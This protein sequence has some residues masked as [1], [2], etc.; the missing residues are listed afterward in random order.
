LWMSV[1]DPFAV[2]N[3]VTV[4]CLK[5]TLPYSLSGRYKIVQLGLLNCR[6]HIINY[7]LR[8]RVKRMV[9]RYRTWSCCV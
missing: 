2:K 5:H 4:G 6:Q 9:Q 3:S 1:T 8:T 7:N